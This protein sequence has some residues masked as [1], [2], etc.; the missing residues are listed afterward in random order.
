MDKIEKYN[1]D[2]NR[3]K[4]ED[5]HVPMDKNEVYV[6]ELVG[7]KKAK[8]NY[9]WLTE[10][11]KKKRQEEEEKRKMEIDKMDFTFDEL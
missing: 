9:F 6:A 2:F 4:H 5:K 1:L 10:S 11:Q 7:E 3:V 8:I